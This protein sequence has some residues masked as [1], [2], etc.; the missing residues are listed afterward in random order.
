MKQE[1]EYHISNKKANIKTKESM[2][3]E[4]Q[5]VDKSGTQE[6]SETEVEHKDKV[7]KLH[8]ALD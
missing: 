4:Y 3:E 2:K 1:R 8:I 7:E 5:T 6:I